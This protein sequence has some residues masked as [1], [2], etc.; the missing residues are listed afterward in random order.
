MSGDAA[1]RVAIEP[2][3]SAHRLGETGA[4]GPAAVPQH[5][6]PERGVESTAQRHQAARDRIDRHAQRTGQRRRTHRMTM[7]QVE[8]TQILWPEHR[9]CRMGQDH[10]IGRRRATHR[11]GDES[12]SR[13]PAVVFRSAPPRVVEVRQRPAP[14]GQQQRLAGEIAGGHHRM[15][16]PQQPQHV[17]AHL[18]GGI[19]R[20]D[21]VL[22]GVVHPV[23]RGVDGR[24]ERVAIASVDRVEIDRGSRGDRMRHAP[25]RRTDL[26]EIQTKCRRFLCDG[27]WRLVGHRLR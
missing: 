24:R 16:L 15:V 4:L 9:R 21:D 26:D 12:V 6:G 14:G 13:S 1:E 22:C 20:P 19:G 3:R 11:R 8:A 2:G 23:E 25:Y 17:A 7:V 5:E 27:G 10:S 18:G